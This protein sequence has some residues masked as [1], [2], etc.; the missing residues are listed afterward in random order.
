MTAYLIL[1]AWWFSMSAFASTAILGHNSDGKSR[2]EMWL[3]LVT[4]CFE[5]CM[6]GA[7]ITLLWWRW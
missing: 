5:V 2:S 3:R 4:L 7:A 1:C 6:A